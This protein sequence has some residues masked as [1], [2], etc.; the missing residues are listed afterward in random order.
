MSLGRIKKNEEK[1]LQGQTQTPKAR[2]FV[3][4]TSI[5]RLKRKK[6][7]DYLTLIGILDSTYN[8]II[9][10][11]LNGRV[12]LFNKAA[13]QFTEYPKE[14]AIGEYINKIIPNTALLSVLETGEA[15]YG[16]KLELN[17]KLLVTNRTPIINLGKVI[18]A[19]GVF[20]DISALETISLELET[21]K[22]LSQELNTIIANCSDAVVMVNSEGI[23]ERVN[24]AYERISGAN[25]EE[26]IGKNLKELVAN[27]FISDSISLAVLNEKKPMNIMQKMHTTEREILFTGIPVFNTQ[28]AVSKVISTGRDLTE[29]NFLRAEL[30]RAKTMQAFYHTELEQLRRQVGEVGNLV[31]S[32][33]S[34]RRV[35]ELAVKVA[36]VDTTVLLLGESGVGKEIINRVI[37]SASKRSNQKLVKVNCAAIPENLLE[38]EFF[39]YVEGA[40]TGAK[41]GGKPGL[42]E[43]AN[44]GTVFLDEI[45]ELPLNLQAKLLRVLQDREIVRIGSS[46]PIKINIRIVAATNKDLASMVKEK[47]FREDLYYRLNVVP[48][49]IPPLRNRREDIIP[50]IFH[51]LSQINEKYSLKKTI[52]SSAID[53]LVRYNWPG[54]VRELENI[55][56]HMLVISFDDE[57]TEKDLPATFIQNVE[58][59][60]AINVN[61]ILPWKDAV[62]ELEQQ[63]LNKAFQIHKSIRGVAKALGVNPSTVLRK[64]RFWDA[65]D[66]ATRQQG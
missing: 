52:S 47:Q 15:N 38:S 39:G 66:V 42:F 58:Q 33:E 18:G 31:F 2:Y 25:A 27:G 17:G 41:K 40:F 51:F 44:S 62:N 21:L 7:V 5:N 4:K 24:P 46:D 36:Q 34:M 50:L 49:I 64:K 61:H 48:I 20:Q 3:N 13:E 30:E 11:D 26:L 28:G 23:F 29:L 32:S 55:I 45:G 9:A 1:G 37:H 22:G 6:E 56:E 8:G 54:N 10:I 43:T 12:T 16:Q 53:K 19:V 60:Q 57:I 35:I 59:L 63:L 14:L 65:H